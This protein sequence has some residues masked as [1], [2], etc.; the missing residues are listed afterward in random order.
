VNADC[1]SKEVNRHGTWATTDP[2]G[3]AGGTV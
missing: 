2:L 3:L 1:S